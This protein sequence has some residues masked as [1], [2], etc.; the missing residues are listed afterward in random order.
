MASP[1]QGKAQRKGAIQHA[2]LHF[3]R[4]D[5]LLP[6]ILNTAAGPTSILEK[7]I[8]PLLLNPCSGDL[9]LPFDCDSTLPLTGHNLHHATS[10]PIWQTKSTWYIRPRR[11]SAPVMAGQRC[12]CLHG[13]LIYLP[14]QLAVGCCKVST[15]M[16]HY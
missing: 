1:F 10:V 12:T 11:H 3:E 9:T 7:K 16:Q 4:L 8:F 15:I 2:R 13:L 6:R 5:W 14:W